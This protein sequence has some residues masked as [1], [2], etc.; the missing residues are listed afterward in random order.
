M[1]GERLVFARDGGERFPWTVETLRA[2]LA[3]E[4]AETVEF[5]AVVLQKDFQN[6]W[7]ADGSRVAVQCAW[8]ALCGRAAV[9]TVAHPMLGDVPCCERCVEWATRGPREQP[10]WVPWKEK[11]GR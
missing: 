9:T 8:F 10:L 11:E 1:N 4:G 5:E 7:R 3:Q 2:H 6:G